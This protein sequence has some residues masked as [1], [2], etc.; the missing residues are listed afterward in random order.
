MSNIASIHYHPD[1]KFKSKAHRR[2]AFLEALR[3]TGS[4][5]FAAAIVGVE[6]TTP[7]YWRRTIPGFAEAWDLA[8]AVPASRRRR[9]YDLPVSRMN[10]R[11][12]V[13]ADRHNQRLARR[14]DKLDFS[15][16]GD[17]QEPAD[18]FDR[19]DLTEFAL[20]TDAQS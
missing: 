2:R 16:P 19:N 4:Q 20:H 11:L 5:S 3:Q 12:L 9:L 10:E 17:S 18:P 8:L 13:Y 7:Y 6:R 1:R 15:T 14:K